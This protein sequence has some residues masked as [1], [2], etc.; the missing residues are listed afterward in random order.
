MVPALLLGVSAFR[1]LNKDPLAT[2]FSRGRRK[3]SDETDIGRSLDLDGGPLDRL[4]LAFT[5]LPKRRLPEFDLVAL[6]VHDP[7]ELPVLRV[8]RLL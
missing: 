6:R 3:R 1:L 2:K 7:S 8:V 5:L 4:Y